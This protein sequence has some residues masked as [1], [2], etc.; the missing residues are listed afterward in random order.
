M[1]KERLTAYCYL[2]ITFILW[3][4]LYVVSK[5]TLGRLPTFTISFFRFVIAFITLT[6]VAKKNKKHKKLR[7]FERQDYPWLLLIGVGGY[8]VAV[9]SQ[10]LGTKY[11]GASLA[12]LLNSLNPVTMTVFAAI[13][14]NEKL[15]GR[16]I[17]GVLLALVGV[18]V[19]LGT[20]F[21]SNTTGI[22]LS[23][24]AVLLWSV[25]SVLMRKITHKYDSMDVTRCGIGIAVV[26]YLPVCVCELV[27]SGTIR[28]DFI[29]I[30]ALLYMGAVCT[31]LAY[32]L[33]NKSLSIL[34]AGTCSAFYPIQPLVSA[35]LGMLLL[36]EQNGIS[37]WCGA[38][39]IAVGIIVNL[40]E[41]NKTKIVP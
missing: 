5:Y 6:I 1:S 30:A 8:F 19:I 14:L 10:L 24:L 15:T 9:G 25:V 28:M 33:W 22:I 41:P 21:Q 26:C 16:K 32:Y 34:E 35:L 39:L 12:S 31:G 20:G 23:V 40:S 37:F 3:G 27:T 11:A 13:F 36:K 7:K 18:Y 4:S 38:I 29:C 17:A 2:S